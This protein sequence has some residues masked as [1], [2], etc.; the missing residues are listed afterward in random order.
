MRNILKDK[1]LNEIE[2]F[3]RDDWIRTSDL[4]VPNDARYQATLH[5]EF[6]NNA[7]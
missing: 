3:S 6:N 5:P 1:T 2:G 4:I 7:I